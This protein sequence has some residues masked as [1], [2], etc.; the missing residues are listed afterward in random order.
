MLMFTC[1]CYA[2]LDTSCSVVRAYAG[3]NICNVHVYMD[4]NMKH[5]VNDRKKTYNT[6]QASHST[7]WLFIN[8]K[9]IMSISITK[10]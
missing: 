6:V 2:L 5:F 1:R 8:T 9:R 10:L 3:V 4:V 7:V